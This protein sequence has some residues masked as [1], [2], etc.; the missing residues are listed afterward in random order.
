MSSAQILLP[1]SAFTVDELIQLTGYAIK[2]KVAERLKLD[3][4]PYTL[5]R[6]GWPVVDREVYRSA[7]LGR[8]AIVQ[9]SDDV[10]NFDRMN[11]R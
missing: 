1:P 3:G 11:R 7:L 10:P 6:T 2:S 9:S 8:H 4:I 5:H